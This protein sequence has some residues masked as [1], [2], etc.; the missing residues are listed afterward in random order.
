MEYLCSWRL[1]GAP[2]PPLFRYLPTSILP[3]AAAASGRAWGVRSLA[4]PSLPSPYTAQGHLRA[5]AAGAL[6]LPLAV[7]E[8]GPQRVV[9]AGVQTGLEVFWVGAATGWGVRTLEALEPGQFVCE[10]A[11]EVLPDVEAEERCLSPPGRDAYLFNLTTPAQCR[12]LGAAVPAQPGAEAEDEP[13]F[14]VDAFACGNVGRFINHACGPSMAANVVPVFV[15]AE[16][17]PG[18]L[19]DARLPRVA[20]FAT[21]RVAAGEEL[22]YDYDMQP[23]EVGSVDGTDRSLACHCGSSAC[24][25]WVY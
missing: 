14:V 6:P 23:G 12:L 3:P 18:A 16:D 7:L 5:L 19:P 22:R 17:A 24:R 2:P 8:R 25:G 13:A 10:Y 15:F 20:L 9:R 1:D 21:R 11:G 4:D